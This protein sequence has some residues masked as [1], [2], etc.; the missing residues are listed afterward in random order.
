MQAKNEV[1][2]PYSGMQQHQVQ[3]DLG[4][5]GKY[6]FNQQYSVSEPGHALRYV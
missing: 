6:A 2:A 1:C 5:T 4:N 3:P